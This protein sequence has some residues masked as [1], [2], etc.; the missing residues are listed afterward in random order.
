MNHKKDLKFGWG[1][2][3]TSDMISDYIKNLNIRYESH[4]WKDES[5]TVRESKGSD[6]R[7]TGSGD[8]YE[9]TQFRRT[10]K[11]CGYS[12]LDESEFKL[13]KKEITCNKIYPGMGTNAIFH[14]IDSD[15]KEKKDEEK[16]I[17]K[18][19]AGEKKKGWFR[20]DIELSYK[21]IGN[22]D[23]TKD[24]E[25]SKEIA[26]KLHGIQKELRLAGEKINHFAATDIKSK[27]KSAI[28]SIEVETNMAIGI[29]D[30]FKK[31]LLYVAAIN[32]RF[33]IGTWDNGHNNDGIFRWFTIITEPLVGDI[34]Y[35]EFAEDYYK[36][37]D[38]NISVWQLKDLNGSI[39]AQTNL[40]I[41]EFIFLDTGFINMVSG[42]GIISMRKGG[43][44]IKLNK[45]IS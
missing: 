33:N 37:D 16:G 24:I 18:T 1:K 45:L 42:S 34:I 25:K 27:I 29:N 26:D 43:E 32:C 30:R 22:R 23:I 10:C 36:R 20:K 31:K 40:E 15:Y 44:M 13:R 35:W 8:Y 11:K 14:K 3:I 39:V 4:E 28:E 2:K 9:W 6:P 21:R 7:E 12:I 38:G 17:L 5:Y 41:G 19:L